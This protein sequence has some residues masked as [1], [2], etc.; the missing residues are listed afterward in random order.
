[1]VQ[2]IDGKAGGKKLLGDPE[3]LAAVRVESVDDDNNARGLP[4]GRHVRVKIATPPTP[5][6]V[7][8]VA[9]GLNMLIGALLLEKRHNQRNSLFGLFLH[10]PVA[11]ILDDSGAHIGRCD[12]D[13]GRQSGAIGMIA[14]DRQHRDR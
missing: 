4:G 7:P 5:A 3:I 10:N 12:S 14:A 1:M 11:R 9:S 8:S 13:L 6:N 2:R